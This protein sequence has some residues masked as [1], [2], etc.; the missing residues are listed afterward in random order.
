MS[1]APILLLHIAYIYHDY[2]YD[3]MITIT[4]I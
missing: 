1:A 3:T 2:A 4:I